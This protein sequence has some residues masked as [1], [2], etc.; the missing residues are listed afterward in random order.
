MGSGRAV[1]I[2]H[3]NN[4]KTLTGMHSW[5]GNVIH[6]TVA[7]MESAPTSPTPVPLRLRIFIVVQAVEETIKIIAAAT[8]GVMSAQRWPEELHILW[9]VLGSP[10]D[11]IST[12]S[13]A[14]VLS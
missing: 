5:C 10:T 9:E 13:H 11:P 1:L 7:A 2:M 8:A 6:K 4:T 3:G 12:Q 14:A